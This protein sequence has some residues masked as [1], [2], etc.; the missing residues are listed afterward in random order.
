MSVAVGMRC[1]FVINEYGRLY[2]W[3]RNAYCELGQYASSTCGEPD[4]THSVTPTH[5][6]QFGNTMKTLTANGSGAACV[7]RMAACKCGANQTCCPSRAPTSHP[8]ASHSTNFR[9]SGLRSRAVPGKIT[10]RQTEAACFPRFPWTAKSTEQWSSNFWLPCWRYGIILVV[11]CP[12]DC[13]GQVPRAGNQ[14]ATHTQAHMYNQH[15]RGMET[16]RHRSLVERGGRKALLET[17]QQQNKKKQNKNDIHESKE[18]VRAHRASSKATR[19]FLTE[20]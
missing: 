6:V 17:L 10:S 3:G 1:T 19:I 12:N 18:K 2:S 11:A 15:T 13:H 9:E 5:V 14:R 4:A 20:R 8:T 7:M 16:T